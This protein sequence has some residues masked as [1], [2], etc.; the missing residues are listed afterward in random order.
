MPASLPVRPG[1]QGGVDAGEALGA[2]FAGELQDEGRVGAGLGVDRAG[3]E[4]RGVGRWASAAGQAPPPGAAVVCE[5]VG[6]V[7]RSAPS[8]A[9]QGVRVEVVVW[10]PQVGGVI[11]EARGRRRRGAG[12]TSSSGSWGFS[13]KTW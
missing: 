1:R 6:W 5:G 3:V 8:G 7:W 12:V 9:D 2:V 13:S 4:G 10:V 11:S